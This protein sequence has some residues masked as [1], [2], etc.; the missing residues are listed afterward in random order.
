MSM[1]TFRILRLCYVINIYICPPYIWRSVTVFWVSDIGALKAFPLVAHWTAWV[2]NINMLLKVKEWGSKLAWYFCKI[3]EMKH[4]F[5]SH[6][7]GRRCSLVNCAKILFILAFWEALICKREDRRSCTPRVSVIGY[8][9]GR[10]MRSS[11]GHVP[12]EEIWRMWWQPYWHWNLPL[13]FCFLIRAQTW[14]SRSQTAIH[15]VGLVNQTLLRSTD[16]SL[17]L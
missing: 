8:Q 15:K 9:R 7:S 6:E 10:G 13:Y 2:S 12:S 4:Q 1:E 14:A 3:Q 11:P 17:L 16:C 5:H